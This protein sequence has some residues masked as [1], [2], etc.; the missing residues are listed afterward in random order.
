MITDILCQIFPLAQRVKDLDGLRELSSL[1]GPSGEQEQDRSQ[2][3]ALVTGAL[4][5]L[6]SAFEVLMLQQR[7]EQV[8]EIQTSGL[9]GSSSDH[10]HGR[11]PRTASVPHVCLS[12]VSPGRMNRGQVWQFLYVACAW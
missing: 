2:V 11:G 5:D 9:S 7:S 8:H 10:R 3:P 12:S 6:G 4:G 1:A